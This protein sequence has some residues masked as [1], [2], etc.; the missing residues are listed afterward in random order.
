MPDTSPFGSRGEGARFLGNASL[1][2]IDQA[3]EAIKAPVGPFQVVPEF[4][5]LY[6]KERLTDLF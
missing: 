5:Y 3:G 6:T 4:R 2:R 1:A